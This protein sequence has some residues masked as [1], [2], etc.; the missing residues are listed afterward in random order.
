MNFF[1]HL[2]TQEYGEPRC[3]VRPGDPEDRVY[4]INALTHAGRWGRNLL[5]KLETYNRVMEG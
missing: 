3:V 5:E 2:C 1:F 4:Y